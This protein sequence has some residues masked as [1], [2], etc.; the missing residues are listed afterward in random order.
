MALGLSPFPIGLDDFFVDRERTPRDE[1]GELDYESLHAIDLER[2]QHD[3][4]QLIAG[5]KVQ[6]PHYD[7]ITGK[8]GPGSIVQL[9]PEEI[10]ILEGIH[11]LN[12]DL[13]PDIPTDQTFRVYASA[14]TQLNLDRYNRVS[15]TD[16]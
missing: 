3:L 13:T 1:E 5:E 9:S 8:Q 16:T 7:F 2:L 11:G 10:I 6:L 14:L 15:T 4:K 12:P